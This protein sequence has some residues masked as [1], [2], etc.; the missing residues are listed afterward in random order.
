MWL[1]SQEIR[2]PTLKVAVFGQLSRVE[3]VVCEVDAEVEQAPEFRYLGLLFS[4]GRGIGSRLESCGLECKDAGTGCNY[5]TPTLVAV[6][7]WFEAP[8]VL[9]LRYCCHMLW[10]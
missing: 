10:V 1:F 8:S 2:V 3:T 9:S 7:L 4:A 5:T 6:S